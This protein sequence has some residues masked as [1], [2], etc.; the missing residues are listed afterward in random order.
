MSPDA[1]WHAI[2]LVVVALLALVSGAAIY[3]HCRPQPPT[4]QF[5]EIELQLEETK[6]QIEETRTVLLQKIEDESK[7]KVKT[8][9]VRAETQI[10]DLGQRPE[11]V[12]RALADLV[13]RHRTERARY[14]Q[15]SSTV[16]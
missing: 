1:R 6:A 2:T 4:F 7:E 10:A 14:T 13:V 12:S 16:R 5:D 8:V 15:T 11:E 9:Y 3:A